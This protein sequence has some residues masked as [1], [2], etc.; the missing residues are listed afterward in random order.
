MPTVALEYIR[1]SSEQ[2]AGE[3]QTSL[4][5]QRAAIG[6]LAERLGVSVIET[7][8][9]AGF[10]GATVTKRPGLKALL[11][12]CLAHRR[13][14]SDPGYVLVLNDSR[15]GRFDD[16]DEAA[17]LR[18]Q[19]KATG[20]LV[21]FA[22]ADDIADP[23]LRHIMRA[24]GGAQ[25]SEYRRNLRANSTRGRHGTVKQGYWSSR[26]PFGYRRAVVYPTAQARVLEKGAPKARGE[27]IKLVAGP[28]DEVAI[29]R[30]VF[31]RYASGAH[32]MKALCRWLNAQPA[33]T[34]GRR[35]WAVS[36]IRNLLENYAYLGAIPARRRTAERME[37]GDYSRHVPEYIVW[38]AHEA[39]V[40]RE[41]WERCQVQ[42]TEIPARGDVFDYRLRGLVLCSTCGTPMNGGGMGSR[43]KSDGQRRR[44]YICNAGRTPTSCPPHAA[45]VLTTLLEEAVVHEVTQHVRR[46]VSPAHV[47]RAFRERMGGTTVAP[48]VSPDKIRKQLLANRARLIAAV[49]AGT[50]SLDD[51]TARLDA[52][53][54]ELAA[55][56]APSAPPAAHEVRP[57]L[58]RLVARGRDLVSL[59]QLATG[60]EL[61]AL[62]RPWVDSMTFD[63]H[64]RTVTLRLRTIAA[65]LA[66]SPLR[67]EVVP[68]KNTIITR[69]VKV[70]GGRP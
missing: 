3:K 56:D 5:D 58:D 37:R 39:L 59:A 60:P 12:Y 34:I 2:Q 6:L 52:N 17:A 51:V 36:T 16:P 7:F 66:A 15:F 33:A 28:A 21:R 62:I 55:L 23:S 25:A 68:D 35:S 4:A 1:V 13:S 20:W 61:R 57:L 53:R 11:A 38:D 48:T 40:A 65:G 63:K 8:E 50:L 41:V 54:A 22:E 26:E 14:A 42:L 10:S 44:F 47:A 30:E 27:R 24:V 70:G 18:F 19:L 43:R 49:E 69:R 29:V 45:T 64:A 32:S 67:A 46:Q 9:D 31:R